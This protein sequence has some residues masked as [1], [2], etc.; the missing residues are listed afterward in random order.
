MI[1][2]NH[3]TFILNTAQASFLHYTRIV[4]VYKLCYFIV[5]T[6]ICLVVNDL[7]GIFIIIISGFYLQM[8]EMIEFIP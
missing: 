7:L 3:V 5:K 2:L 6:T 4:Q 8:H 1:N